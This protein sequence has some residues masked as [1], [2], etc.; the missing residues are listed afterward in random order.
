MNPLTNDICRNSHA[1]PNPGGTE[2]VE[3]PLGE[4]VEEDDG[5]PVVQQALS[6]H[7]NLKK[8]TNHD[9]KLECLNN[10]VNSFQA[11]L[12][13]RSSISARTHK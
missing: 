11:A 10:V 4:D 3:E 9:R 7:V 1:L 2:L 6:G 8:M 13:V 5:R 12:A